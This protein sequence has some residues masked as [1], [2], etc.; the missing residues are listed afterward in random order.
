MSAEVRSALDA[1]TAAVRAATLR[2]L[3]ARLYALQMGAR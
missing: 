1:R 2:E 3:D